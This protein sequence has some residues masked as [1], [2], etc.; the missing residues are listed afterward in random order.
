MEEKEFKK[1]MNELY[2]P[3]DKDFVMV[4][5]PEL[6]FAMIDGEGDPKNETNTHAL[7]W[8]FSAIYPIKLAVKKHMG[9]EF[10][11]PPLEGLFWADNI[12]DFI[13][14][15][16]DG[17]GNKDKL[18]WRMMI[19]TPDWVDGE[20]FDEAVA[21]AGKKLG[22][23]PKSLRMEKFNEGSCVQ[24]M[25]IG[26]YIKQIQIMAA[27]HKEFLPANNLVPNGYHHEIYLND[28]KRVAPEKLRTVLR[29]PVKKQ[30]ENK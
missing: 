11:D 8:L 2:L 28:P 16:K 18:K 26:P 23:A 25:H 29:Q 17:L 12:E 19:I 21:T 10:V 5:V 13:N 15:S 14:M 24:I 9:R 4:D 22:K 30:G 1:R 7:R 6:Q 20:M 27:M 3:S